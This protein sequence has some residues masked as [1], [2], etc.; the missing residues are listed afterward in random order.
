SHVSSKE[1]LE[2]ASRLC[3][4][5]GIRKMQISIKEPYD[6]CLSVLK[7]HFSKASEDTTEENIQARLRAVIWMALSNKFG[8]L[9]LTAGNKSELAT[10]Y[11]T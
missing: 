11:T 9:V 5:L 8:W 3:E 4:N 10:G 1:S 7:E 6:A 2:D